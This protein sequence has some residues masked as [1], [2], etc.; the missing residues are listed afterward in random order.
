MTSGNLP[1][2]L[3]EI[4]QTFQIYECVLCAEAL[5]QFL[6]E[7]NLSGKQISLFTGST[8]D[9]FCNIYHEG[10]QKNISI[11]GRHEAIAIMI[12]GQETVFDNIHPAGIPRAHWLKVLYCPIQDLGG[13][14][15][16]TESTF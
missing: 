2:E 4:A 7:R 12:G 16:V 15:E 5:R 10:L 8:E 6:E 3:C 9:P 11:N 13:E 1:E 14:F